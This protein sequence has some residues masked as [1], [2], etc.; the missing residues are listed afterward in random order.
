MEKSGECRL[1]QPTAEAEYGLR[2]AREMPA[3]RCNC[4]K[5]VSSASA[6]GSCPRASLKP[7]KA[8]W[9]PAQS[10]STAP[11]WRDR[12]TVTASSSIVI[13]SFIPFW[14]EYTPFTCRNSA[15]PQTVT[16]HSFELFTTRARQ[17]Q[18]LCVQVL[19]CLKVAIPD[20]MDLMFQLGRSTALFVEGSKVGCEVRPHAKAG[21]A[22]FEY[23]NVDEFFHCPISEFC[24]RVV[25]RP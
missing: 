15:Y 25:N 5:E 3:H 22:W 19:H 14:R 17:L 10:V 21:P 1:V 13:V 4:S 16:Q 23:R 7:K 9:S 20:S 11:P 2:A 24:S 6:S 18:L 12:T 8:V